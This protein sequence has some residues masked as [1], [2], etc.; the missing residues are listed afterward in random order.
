MNDNLEDMWKGADLTYF[1]A[2]ARKKKKEKNFE[3]SN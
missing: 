3:E 2:L 1:K